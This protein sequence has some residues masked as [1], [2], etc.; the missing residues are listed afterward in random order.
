MSQL[1]LDAHVNAVR[2][3]PLLRRWIT[4]ERLQDIRPRQLVLDDRV[5][6]ILLRLK[7]PTFVTIDSD[8]DDPRLCNPN[9]CILYLALHDKEQPSIPALLRV[10]LR[11]SEF[12]ARAKRMG[13][14]AR[15]ASNTGNF[16]IET[17]GLLCGSLCFAN[18]KRAHF[19]YIAST[20]PEAG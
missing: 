8:F 15:P 12:R 18:V 3:L 11:R 10:L 14:L 20:F 9:Y 13:K 4:V 2:V 17:H 6:E 5:P 7:Q 19:V 16:R 1:I